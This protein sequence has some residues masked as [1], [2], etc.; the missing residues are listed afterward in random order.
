[1]ME[2]KARL[3][4]LGSGTS[5]GIP[6]IGCDC[7]VC[8]SADP[9]DR[10]L[11][12][13]VLVEYKGLSVLIDAGPDFRYQMLRAGIRHLDAILLT[14]NHK[15]HTGGIDD[16]RSFNLLEAHPINI[17]CQKYVENSL[18]REYSYAFADVLYPGAPEIHVHTI[19]GGVDDP[20]G[21]ARRRATPGW[22]SSPARS[23]P[24]R[25]PL[26]RLR[27]PSDMEIR[28]RISPREIRSFPRG[29]SRCGDNPHP[30]MAPQGEEAERPRLPFRQHSL[31]Y[32]H[33][34]T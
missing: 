8:S 5:Q 19:G 2:D 26:Q 21:A 6:M 25:S 12:A 28:Q 17:Y 34:P 27:G 10:R 29:M 14:H 1:M 3:T 11:R 20:S 7:P 9:R 13:S 16:V 18:R 23:R 4:F 15:D 30:G 24:L 32:G 33:E 31:P 22:R